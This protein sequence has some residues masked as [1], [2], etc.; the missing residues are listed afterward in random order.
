MLLKLFY[1]K[2]PLNNFL[3]NEIGPLQSIEYPHCRQARGLTYENLNGCK[4]D[5]IN[6]VAVKKNVPNECF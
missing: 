1:C 2:Q 4:K 3:I 5:N 6:L